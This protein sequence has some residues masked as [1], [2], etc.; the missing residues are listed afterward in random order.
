MDVYHTLYH[1]FIQLWEYSFSYLQF[2]ETNLITQRKNF[3]R[4]WA[5]WPFKISKNRFIIENRP[6]NKKTFAPHNCTRCQVTETS[7]LASAIDQSDSIILAFLPAAEADCG[8]SILTQSASAA[9]PIRNAEK[10]ESLRTIYLSP[11]GLQVVR[12]NFVF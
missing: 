8:I 7:W 1:Y 6:K 4:K 5:V 2:N 9:G 10:M 3:V 11:T 12:L